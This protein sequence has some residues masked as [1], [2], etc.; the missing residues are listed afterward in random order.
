[1][2][3]VSEVCKVNYYTLESCV[4]FRSFTEKPLYEIRKRETVILGE[5]LDFYLVAALDFRRQ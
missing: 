2:R 1:M 3:W 4:S 5:L